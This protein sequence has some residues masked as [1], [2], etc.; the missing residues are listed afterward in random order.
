MTK[1]KQPL[2][3][4]KIFNTVGVYA[5]TLKFYNLLEALKAYSAIKRAMFYWN[6]R[7]INDEAI[8][9]GLQ[10]LA[11]VRRENPDY[12]KKGLVNE[13]SKKTKK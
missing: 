11:T 3:K 8:L 9:F 1:K 6:K 5:G 12:F 2:Y 4:I 7:L 10:I 13:K